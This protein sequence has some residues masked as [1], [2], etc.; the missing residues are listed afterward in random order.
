MIWNLID[1]LLTG[2]SLGHLYYAVRHKHAWNV[3]EFTQYDFAAICWELSVV[4]LFIGK[5]TA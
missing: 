2:L 5:M 4:A 3:P 1:H